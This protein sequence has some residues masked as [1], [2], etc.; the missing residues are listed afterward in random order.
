[1]NSLQAKGYTLFHH[2]V[3]SLSCKLRRILFYKL[4]VLSTQ[5]INYSLYNGWDVRHKD[6]GGFTL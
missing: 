3:L 6:V 4:L 1:M 5:C 2:H